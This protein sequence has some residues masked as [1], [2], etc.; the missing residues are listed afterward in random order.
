MV[1]D[2]STTAPRGL[3]PAAPGK[4]RRSDEAAGA[5][6][7]SGE[8]SDE[9]SNEAS[10]VDTASQTGGAAGAGQAV[11]TEDA[12]TGSRR[13]V[14][15]SANRTDGV[16][17]EG[18]LLGRY[19]VRRL[20]GEGGMGRVYL[21]RDVQ[22][23]RSVALKVVRSVAAGTEQ[24]K[25]ILG[26]ARA[27][28]N[29]N[30]PHIVQLYD[31][32]EHAGSLYLVL[33]YVDGVTLPTRTAESPPSLDEGLRHARAIADALVHAHKNSVFHCDLKPSNIMVGRDGRLRVVDFGIAYKA[34]LVEPLNAGTPEWMAP[35]QSGRNPPTDRVDIWALGIL[36]LE[37]LTG[38]PHQGSLLSR[39]TVGAGGPARAAGEVL[40]SS[41]DPERSL[42]AQIGDCGLPPRIAEL[43]A[44]SLSFKASDRPS[45]ADWLYTLDEVIAGR[46]DALDEECPFRGL[47]SFDEPDARNFFG[48][49]ADVDAFLERL[50]HEPC[51][52]I[53]GPSGVGKS[54]FL[55]A[56]VVPRL[57]ARA[58][59]TVLSFRPG[60]EPIAALARQVLL[61]SEVGGLPEPELRREIAALAR[62]LYETPTLLAARL[63]TLAASCGHKVL[64]CVDQLEEVF[65]QGAS[66]QVRQRFLEMIT[67]AA[68]DAHD[69]VRVAFTLRDDFLG[70]VPELRALFVLRRLATEELRRTIVG[71]LQ[72]TGYRFD[73]PGVVDE[74]L[75]EVSRGDVADLPLVQFACRALWDGRDGE[76]RLLRRATYTRLGGI[77][78]AL[79]RHAEA[80][81]AQL[82]SAEVRAARQLLLPLVGGTT[83]RSVPRD[84]LLAQA[85]ET[86]AV[87]DRLLAA[88][89]LV[90]HGGSRGEAPIVEI[91]HESLLSSWPQLV[92]W[93]EE[94]RDERRLLSELSDVAL[95]WR[96]QGKRVAESWSVGD[97]AA[98]R[99]RAAQL[100]LS[101]PPIVEEFFAAVE[102]RHR[103]I[104]RRRLV[105]VAALSAVA[106]IAASGSVL[107][108]SGVQVRER[109]AM[110]NFGRVELRLHLFDYGAGH[111][112][113]FVDAD[114]YP[115]L[116]W[117]LY[118]VMPD[119]DYQKGAP[120]PD[121]LV[122]TLS[123]EVRGGARVDVVEAPGGILFLAVEGRG[124]SGERCAPSLIRLRSWPNYSTSASAGAIPLDISVPTCEAS[125][126]DTIAIPAGP[127]V[128]GGYGERPTRFPDDPDY[129]Y[130]ES[131]I[132]LP[133]YRV[134]RTEVSNA[135]FKPFARMD[136]LTGYLRPVYPASDDVMHRNNSRPEWPVTSIDAIEAE[137]FCR[138]L[139]KEL[140]SEPQWV[141]A[142]RGGL[143]VAPGG[144]RA[145]VRRLFPWGNEDRRGC[146][147]LHGPGDP[148]QWT[149]A[150]TDFEC[151]KSPYGVLNLVGNVD[152]W[153]KRDPDDTD[154]LR[155]MRGGSAASLEELEHHTTLYRNHREARFRDYQ[156]GLRCA[157]AAAP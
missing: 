121:G 145:L 131:V 24:A 43:I 93:L 18:D 1:G 103:Q 25:R 46:G 87:L 69:P 78:G 156:L 83:R 127:F 102:Q 15:L 115:E 147:N 98:A 112:T 53:L 152:E 21:G 104:R 143:D 101:V 19:Q 49:E 139:G 7:A 109:R 71:P 82:S 150:V 66:D 113:R 117:R 108:I 54:S 122:E 64:V 4:R 157:V 41:F 61:A 26:E 148:S 56:G 33:E 17:A 2:S 50:R 27:I 135:A 120:V 100:E 70:K 40:A 146:V 28:A 60:A 20:L 14:T 5:D 72:R 144:Q 35:E 94:S 96:R 137:G 124:K 128:Y 149:A 95:L 62:A 77:S 153:M 68:D 116:R 110:A 111:A 75:A 23:G 12:V 63:A 138:F 34:E 85:P 80:A 119:D 11:G 31:Y 91:A 6:L 107:W 9:A 16:L 125:R 123:S 140:I 10:G 132:D 142:A 141:K 65:T 73:D 81:L 86:A 42:D 29:L 3:R 114:A 136:K 155:T 126:Y 74:M 58:P 59:W 55:H 30:H 39:T 52:P 44:R 51:L 134:D 36:T 99:S 89:L 105:I 118:Q 57:R 47:A 38:R 97:L 48:R 45:A 37:L 151:G 67:S 133:A 88:R 8:A 129:V 130:E 84:Q 13:G 32:G 22:L 92:R 90:Q 106:A 154:P 76:H 79:G